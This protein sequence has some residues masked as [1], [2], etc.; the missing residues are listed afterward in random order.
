MI[1][2]HPAQSQI[3]Q[4]LHRFRVLLCGRRFGKTTLA[5]WEMLGVALA[6]PGR[7]IAYLAP[8]YQQA[9]DIAWAELKRIAMP[10]ASDIN[11][12][13]LEIRVKCKLM[14][15]VEYDPKDPDAT[16]SKISLRGWESVDTL[17]GQK[18]DFLVLDEVASMRNF[19]VGWDEVLSPA[20]I[21]NKGSAM[22]IGTPK[23]FNH[24]YDLYNMEAKNP[25]FKS[26]HFTTYDNPHMPIEEIERER[27]AKTEDV[28]AQEFLADFRKT[29]GLVYKEFDRKK[30]VVAPHQIPPHFKEVLGGADPGF[31]HKAS[32]L[33]IG[34]DHDGRYF[35]FKEWVHTEK[36]DA[37]IADYVAGEKFQR[38]YPDP[39]NQGFIEELKRRKV[40]LREV[41]KGPGSVVKGINIV[42]EL[43][44]SNLL[45]ISSDCV[46]LIL[47]LET[48]SY[49]DNNKENPLKENDDEVDSLR[50]PLMMDVNTSTNGPSIAYSGHRAFGQQEVFGVSGQREDKGFNVAHAPRRDYGQSQVWNATP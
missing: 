17:R 19:W 28:F 25:D 39:E 24:F 29:E 3:A 44:K 41:K 21:D 50:Y 38:T 33:S 2:F 47:G 18:F 10:I 6:R 8:T 4:D 46:N 9:R 12:S 45:Y 37:D 30:H 16:T 35:V 43:F 26:F 11:E 14:D 23:G 7:N 27:R 36:T 49:G 48:Y 13:R 31:R 34:K 1:Q 15:G 32:V 5:V 40:N 22:F 42:R 20:L